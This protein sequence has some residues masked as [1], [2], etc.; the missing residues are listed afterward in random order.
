MVCSMQV[1][2]TALMYQPSINAVSKLESRCH[3]S[4]RHANSDMLGAHLC[5]N[6][7]QTLPKCTSHP[8]TLHGVQQLLHV[9]FKGLQHLSS[10]C[11]NGFCPG[12]SQLLL[13]L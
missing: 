13:Q 8:L 9:S 3:A 7:H 6:Q 12:G 5:I 11:S 1:R 4:F 2:V 10:G